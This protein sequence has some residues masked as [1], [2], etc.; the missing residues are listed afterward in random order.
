MRN[1][2]ES[3]RLDGRQETVRKVKGWMKNQNCLKDKNY[4]FGLLN[5]QREL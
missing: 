3:E 4:I 5:K 2:S 1:C